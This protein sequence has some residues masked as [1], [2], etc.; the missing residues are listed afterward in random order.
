MGIWA[1]ESKQEEGCFLGIDR[2]GAQSMLSASPLHVLPHPHFWPSPRKTSFF[3]LHVAICGPV[4][5]L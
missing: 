2:E 3:D 5:L 1:E 4:W